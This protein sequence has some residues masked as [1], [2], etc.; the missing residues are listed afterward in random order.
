MKDEAVN[1]ALDAFVEHWGGRRNAHWTRVFERAYA[2]FDA[3]G[4][5]HDFCLQSAST[6]VVF[7]GSNRLI[8]S[9]CS[10]S[11]RASEAHSSDRF[12]E[13]TREVEGS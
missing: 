11:F 12:I 8:W 1:K 13:A 5:P 9:L 4:V 6:G 3:A 7:G 2:V 10:S